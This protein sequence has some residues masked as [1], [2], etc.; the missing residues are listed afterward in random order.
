MMMKTS[1]IDL[2]DGRR[3]GFDEYGVPDGRPLFYFHGTPSCRVEWRLWCA[4]PLLERHRIRLIAPDRPGMGLSAPR[5]GR[6]FGDWPADVAELADAL[7]IARFA[8]LG[9]SGGGPH[10]AACALRIPE[11]LT[12]VGISSGPCSFE[13]PGVTS[14]IHPSVRQFD[15]LGRDRPSLS[16]ILLTF[17]KLMAQYAPRQLAAQALA[18]LPPVDATVMRMPELQAGVAAMTI[19][20]MRQ[21]TRGA[22]WEIALTASPW[23]FRLEDIRI[24]VHLWHGGLDLNCPPAMGHHMAKTI[25]DC[26]ATFFAD[27]GHLSLLI[28]HMDTVLRTLVD[29]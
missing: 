23:D 6:R 8:V 28:H 25:P 14:G 29:R 21:G 7:G 12:A 3:L 27:E 1:T 10:A 19:E 9:A 5:P 15:E 16:R 11:R 20:A 18:I 4:D 26:R 13:V 17:M 22:Q 2:K 24:P